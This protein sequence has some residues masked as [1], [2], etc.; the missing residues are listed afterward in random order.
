MKTN[1]RVVV[2]G[3]GVVGCSVLYHLTKLGWSDVMLL[4]RSEL[5]SGS[6]WHAAG[7]FHTLNGDTNMAALQGYTIRLYKE[8]EE[9][10]GMSCGLHHVGGVTLADNQERF[11]MLLAERAKHRYM[12][13][14]TEIVGPEEIAKIAPVTNIEG[15]LG[16]LYD[17]LDGHLDPSGTTYAYAKAARLGGATIEINTKVIETNQRSDGTWDVVTERGTIHTEHLVNAGGLW[18][19]EVAAMAGVYLPLHPMEHQYIVTDDIPEIFGRD[20]EHPH[21]MDPAGES[22]LRQEGRG[23]CIGF[24]EQRCRPWAVNGTPW[25]F[26]HELL[27]D[28]FD[29]ITES[30]EFAYKRFPV[31]EKA[32]V[33]NVIHGP[34][35]FAP[36]GN[37]L[38]GPVPGKRNYWSACGV[39]AGF[40]Q[41]GGV[42]LMLAQWM[43]EG[44][45]ER[46]TMAMD[47]A[48]FGDWINPGYTLPKVIENYQKRFSVSYPNEELPAARP[49]RTTPMY[50]IFDNMGAVWGAQYGLEVV[51]Y[52]AEGEEPRFETPSFRRSNAFEATRR[53]VMGVRENVGI[54]ETHNFGKYRVTGEGA[55]DWLNHIMAGRIPEKGR[56]S[57]TPMLSPKG[58]LIGDFTVSCLGEHEFQLTASY[59]SQAFHMRWF[60][61]N[62]ADGVRVENISDRCT[63]FQIAGPNATALLQ[64]VTRDDP[65]TMRF[66]DVRPMVVG[67]VECLVQRVSYT[68]DLGYEIYCDPTD[69]RALWHQL[70]AAGQPMGLRPF[71]MRAMMSLRLDKFFGS[72]MR[73]FSPDYTA[74]E[75]GLDRFI[76]WGKEVEFI[77]KAAAVRERQNGSDRKL[78]VFE[79][80]TDDA[81]VVA[82]EPVWINGQVKGFCT[83]GGYSHYAQKSIAMAL[84][85][86]ECITDTL[87]AEIEILGK[88]YSAKRITTPF[89]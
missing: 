59:G 37:P 42:G 25:D 15:I 82:Y 49:L 7:G 56:L 73:E 83:S 75:T 48:R 27:P 88:M 30:I 5:T 51:N 6:T 46:D 17:P 64:K 18:A 61:K 12:G 67:M 84:V 31:L 41:G 72:W 22:Y 1:S 24:Y 13:L 50:D 65:E 69:Q 43:I 23:L 62:I 87:E 9:I 44:E 57:L 77:G 16:G 58:R 33:K 70:W 3:G 76:S 10:T 29:K 28:D 40:S 55:R 68:G 38:V 47:V 34:F 89:L 79:V 71:G 80:D 11:D 4:E 14:E 54:N 53:E 85:P 8:L 86:G 63:G 78:V 66:L 21:V 60:D 36:D 2:I 81:D 74:A 52:F 20:S 32:G 26:G 35:T 19:R 39:M 45:T